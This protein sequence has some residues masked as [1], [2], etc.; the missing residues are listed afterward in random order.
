MGYAEGVADCVGEGIE[1]IVG[2]AVEVVV[3][4]G[5]GEEANAVKVK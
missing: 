5:V 1:D 2:V 4:I 3:I